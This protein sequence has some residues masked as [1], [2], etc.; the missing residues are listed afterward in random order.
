ML[1]DGSTYFKHGIGCRVF[2]TWGEVNFNFGWNGEID[3]FDPG[4]LWDCLRETRHQL[5][6]TWEGFKAE[7][8]RAEASGAVSYDGVLR[9]L[10]RSRSDE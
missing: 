5:F 1:V 6:L 10:T 9:R 3:G 8:E 7:L 4:F 2:T